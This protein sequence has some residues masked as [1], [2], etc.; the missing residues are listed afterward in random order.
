MRLAGGLILS[1]AMKAGF[2]FGLDRGIAF[3]TAMALGTRNYG[4]TETLQGLR[5]FISGRSNTKLQLTAIILYP[6][7]VFMT[8]M[9]GILLQSMLTVWQFAPDPY[10]GALLTG[11]Y[12]VTFSQSVFLVFIAFLIAIVLLGISCIIAEKYIG[13]PCIDPMISLLG[14]LDRKYVRGGC[15]NGQINLECE[16]LKYSPVGWS[17][18]HNGEFGHTVITDINSRSIFKDGVIYGIDNHHIGS[19]KQIS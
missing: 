3:T 19:E 17:A 7:L 5:A 11:Y 12:A 15:L 10:I 6:L 18:I 1:Q 9:Y 13:Y 4:I 16:Q 8:Q 14:S 2:R